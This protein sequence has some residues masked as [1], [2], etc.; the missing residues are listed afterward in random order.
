MF[1]KRQRTALDAGGVEQIVDDAE[2]ARA[3]GV[4]VGGIAA[5]G[6]VAERAQ[7]FG[8]EDFGEAQHGVE[9]RLQFVAHRGEEGAFGAA[10]FF[11]FGQRA[12]Q[13][14]LCLDLAGDVFHRAFVENKLAR[15]VAHGAGVFRD[16][17]H[18]AIVA[19]DLG[20]EIGHRIVGAH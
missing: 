19:A 16:P 14:V 11:H 8:V 3:A 13:R 20:D 4:D 6:L 10:G 17:D 15:P 1:G 7:H 12:A 2:Q 5:I 18:R 9:R